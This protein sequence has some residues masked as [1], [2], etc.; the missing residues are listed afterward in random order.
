MQ[1]G[2]YSEMHIYYCKK[3]KKR[4]TSLIVAAFFL[5]TDLSFKKY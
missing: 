2:H 1:T 4:D 3:K 5:E